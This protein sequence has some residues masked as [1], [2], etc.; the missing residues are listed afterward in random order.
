VRDRDNPA[1]SEELRNIQNVFVN[2]DDS[3]LATYASIMLGSDYDVEDCRKYFYPQLFLFCLRIIDNYDKF[4]EGR[5]VED[6]LYR[7][8]DPTKTKKPQSEKE[9]LMSMLGDQMLHSFGKLE[10]WD[11]RYGAKLEDTHEW[12]LEWTDIQN[13]IFHTIP[14]LKEYK[15][16]TENTIKFLDVGCGNSSILEE[17]WDYGITDVAG[18]DFCEIVITFMEERKNIVD[19]ESI[20]YHLMDIREMTFPDEHFDIILDK[21]C[22]DCLIC[23]PKT[24][25][26]VE[27]AMTQISRVL[28]PN[29]HF[30]LVS[31]AFSMD[32]TDLLY[33][34]KNKLKLSKWEIIEGRAGLERNINFLIFTK[35]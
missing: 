16:N 27:Q 31:S 9:K 10:F 17:L 25:E 6:Y 34:R 3:K 32:K 4:L 30:L 24:V 23:T 7:F 13:V 35:E 20:Q 29:G 2:F 15:E 33:L 19:R 28:K 12:Y 5:S 1:N 18:I 11:T 26:N 14:I 8:R 21:G 22:L